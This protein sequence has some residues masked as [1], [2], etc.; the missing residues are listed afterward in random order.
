MFSPKGKEYETSVERWS[1]TDCFENGNSTTLSYGHGGQEDE[2]AFN[3]GCESVLSKNLKG[4]PRRR[5][6][7]RVSQFIRGENI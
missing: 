7:I 2:D 3:Q 1:L 5:L 6:I 4:L